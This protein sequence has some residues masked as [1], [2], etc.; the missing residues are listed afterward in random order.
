MK[1][2]S[3]INENTD[4]EMN[5]AQVLQNTTRLPSSYGGFASLALQGVSKSV[6]GDPT[7]SCERSEGRNWDSYR[8]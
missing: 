5:S 7:R 8:I 2:I 4:N 1:C 3:L 6:R